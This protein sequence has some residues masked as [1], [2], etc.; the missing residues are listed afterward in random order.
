[1]VPELLFPLHTPALDNF[2]MSKCTGYFP[3]HF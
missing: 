2:R 1:V 3:R